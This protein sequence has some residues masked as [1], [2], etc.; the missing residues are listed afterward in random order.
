[1]DT[2]PHTTK[3]SVGYHWNQRWNQETPQDKWQ[4]KHN[5]TESMGCSKN[6]SK[7][8][9]YSDTGLKKEEKSQKISHLKDLEEGQMR[10][11][12]SREGRKLNQKVNK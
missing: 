2:K 8:E 9:V 4:W 1:M 11:K 6:F 10:P 3:K 7:R 12:I 5:L